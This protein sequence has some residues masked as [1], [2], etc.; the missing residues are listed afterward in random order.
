MFSLRQEGRGPGGLGPRVRGQGS[1]DQ[2]RAGNSLEKNVTGLFDVCNFSGEV[3]YRCICTRSYVVRLCS[4][5]KRYFRCIHR[6]AE[7]PGRC[8]GRQEGRGRR[9]QDWG[10]GA[11][12][13]GPEARGRGGRGRGQWSKPWSR[14]P[15]E[16]TGR[17][18]ASRGGAGEVG[19]GGPGDRRAWGRGRA[20]TVRAG[21]PGKC[22]VGSSTHKRG[23]LHQVMLSVMQ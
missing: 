5:R 6:L 18:T 20:P 3:G 14:T 21:G 15:M 1:G 8:R 19:A 16:K 11:G 23:R 2:G 4:M 10:S 13:L 22:V 7:S 9:A 12:G 17:S